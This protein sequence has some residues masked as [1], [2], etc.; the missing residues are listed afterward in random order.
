MRDIWDFSTGQ[1]RSVDELR[2]RARHLHGATIKQSKRIQPHLVLACICALPPAWRALMVNDRP[3][4]HGDLYAERGA[5][6]NELYEVYN[7]G[8][9]WFAVVQGSEAVRWQKWSPLDYVTTVT[10]KVKVRKGAGIA[11]EASP[12]HPPTTSKCTLYT[13]GGCVKNSEVNNALQLA[14]AGCAVLNGC[15][16][17][18]TRARVGIYC[19]V[20]TDPGN[21]YFLGATRGT[22]NTGELQGV[23]EAL[24]WLR[25]YD[26][27][28]DDAEIYVDSKYAPGVTEARWGFSTN[29]ALI[30]CTQSILVQVRAVRNVAFFWVAGH[31]GDKFNDIADDLATAGQ[32]LDYD[33]RNGCC[34]GRFGPNA[35]RTLLEYDPRTGGNH[36]LTPDP[37]QYNTVTL[38]CVPSDEEP[39]MAMLHRV[40]RTDDGT[41]RGFSL[42]EYAKQTERVTWPAGR[43][44]AHF[45]VRT[46]RNTLAAARRGNC[47]VMHIHAARVVQACPSTLEVRW[48]SMWREG[49]SSPWPTRVQDMWWKMASGGLYVA[50]QRR[51]YPDPTGAFCRVCV[52]YEDKVVLD[53]EQHLYYECPCQRPLWKWVRDGLRQL[54]F[55]TA[56]GAAFMLYGLQTLHRLEHLTDD[57]RPHEIRVAQYLRAA[58]IEAFFTSRSGTM[59][60]EATGVHPAVGP[61]RARALLRGYVS[62]DWYAATRAH[63]K[64]TH[65]VH[66]PDGK[67]RGDRPTS[68]DIFAKTWRPFARVLARR[69]LDWIGV[70]LA[71]TE[72]AGGPQYTG[73]YAPDGV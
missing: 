49:W 39:A 18:A 28:T 32:D 7:M 50:H 19:P 8:Q 15:R 22:N 43:G 2:N 20:F 60:P 30:H 6:L 51:K 36:A 41:P 46:V 4:Q 24:L 1:D 29:H 17:T 56:H 38:R 72:G 37:L 44:R 58:A 55:H 16:E 57:M 33:T 59:T 23:A 52:T 10:P 65:L 14:G 67:A 26:Q 5:C 63:K 45:N 66:K 27:T 69:E 64:H 71:P 40:T 11:G 3:P 34:E 70:C 54:G 31:S 13:D 68:I 35:P 42:S 62:V 47:G 61:S 48:K 9:V 25:D 53:T 21:P 73:G 12:I